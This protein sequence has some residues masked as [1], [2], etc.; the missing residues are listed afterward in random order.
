MDNT[1][2]SAT[3]GVPRFTGATHEQQLGRAA[4]DARS[5]L[6]FAAQ[7]S[8]HLDPTVV[9]DLTRAL[10]ALARPS[11]PGTRPDPKAE[12]AFWQKYDALTVAMAPTSAATIR[13]TE[14]AKAGLSPAWMP[15]L[16][17]VSCLLLVIALQLLV[18]GA[19]RLLDDINN[20]EKRLGDLDGR[21]S[22]LSGQI[23]RIQRE[24]DEGEGGARGNSKPHTKAEKDRLEKEIERITEE[25]GRT[26]DKRQAE[27]QKSQHTHDLVQYWYNRIRVVATLPSMK[28]VYAEKVAHAEARYKKVLESR[29]PGTPLYRLAEAQHRSALTQIEAQKAR[30][31]QSMITIMLPQINTYV[32]PALLGVLGAMTFVLRSLSVQLANYSYTPQPRGTTLARMT[33]G[34]VAGVFGSLMVS[35]GANPDQGLR[36][37]PPLVLPFVFGYGVD[38]FFALLDKVVETFTSV[39]TTSAR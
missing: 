39:R 3:S 2:K 33:L 30:A 36:V 11:E 23:Q 35:A 15:L 24:M 25:V 13:H 12:A 34:M 16:V 28:D 6:G 26:T 19:G 22:E 7:T 1:F 5:L 29:S 20:S 14:A 9:E 27:V 21:S 31:A 18:I 38:I 32:L 10:D 17:T 8:R 37:L 4:D